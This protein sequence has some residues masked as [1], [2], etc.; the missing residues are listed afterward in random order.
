MILSR[1]GYHLR[2]DNLQ[3]KM[4]MVGHEAKGVNP[5]AKAEGAFLKQEVEMKAV[6]VGQKNNLPPVAPEDNM[7]KS[8]RKLDAWFA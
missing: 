4:N 5:I 8:T 3:G 1:S 6:S 7:I 2:G